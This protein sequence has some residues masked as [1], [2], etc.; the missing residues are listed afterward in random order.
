M[1]KGKV[2]FVG[3]GPGDVGLITVKGQ[4]AIEKADVIL[5]DRLLN[6]KLLDAA[7]FDCELIYCGKTPYTIGIS[8]GEINELLVSKALAGHRVV[9]LKGGDP[10]VFGRVGEEAES[11]KDEGIPFEVIPGVTSSIA[12]SMYAGVP[13]THRD[14]GRSFAMV[15]GHDRTKKDIDWNGLVSIDT[16]AFYM[17]VANLP[18]IRENLINHGKAGNTPALVIQWGTY[19][20]Q[21]SVEGTLDDIVERVS[22]RSLGN[23]AITLV[24]DII[25]LRGKLQWFEKKPLY[26]QRFLVAR[27]GTAKSSLAE[28]L[29][30]LGGEV[31]E[32]PKWNAAKVKI[33]ESQ[34]LSFLS[35]DRILFT[36][37]ESVHGFLDSLTEHAIDFRRISSKLYVL[38]RKS[39]KALQQRGLTAELKSEM[40]EAGTLLVVGDRNRDLRDSAHGDGDYIQSIAK[41]VDERFLEIFPRMLDGKAVGTVLFSNRHSVDMLMQYGN[42][43]DVDIEG[44]LNQ[45]SIG[46]IGESTGNR[47]QDYGFTLDMMPNEPSVEQLV[48]LIVNRNVF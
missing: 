48:E 10:A 29:H 40:A 18:Y 14:Y 30:E 26:G 21:E 39:K 6:P 23:P 4:K 19:G 47:L 33:E 16:V 38:S 27:T 31:I 11:L 43:A 17:G 8:Q 25:S 35:Y 32:F 7:T 28:A 41:F 34:L 42:K 37:P 3:A 44:L 45:A 9:R 5:Y 12:A 2:Y 24:G 46:V 13:V 1:T 20:R 22:E 15:T 36:S